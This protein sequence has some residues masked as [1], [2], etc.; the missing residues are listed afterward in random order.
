MGQHIK[1][2]PKPIQPFEDPTAPAS[3]ILPDV[4]PREDLEFEPMYN[5]IQVKLIDDTPDLRSGNLFLPQNSTIVQQGA[6]FAEVIAVGCGHLTADG[7]VRPL[8]VKP[9][10][11]IYFAALAGA[12]LRLGREEFQVTREE[13]ILGIVRKKEAKQ[14]VN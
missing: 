11:R 13:E 8:K 5:Y 9:G 12:R 14:A 10:D 6:R 1:R 7:S 2:V 3:L 4:E